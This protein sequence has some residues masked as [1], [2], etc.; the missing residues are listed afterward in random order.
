[1]DNTWV[2]FQKKYEFNPLHHHSGVFSWVI[3]VKIPYNLSDEED[4]FITGD[5]EKGRKPASK[6]H[7]VYP[8]NP[9]YENGGITTALLDVDKSYEGKILL[10]PSFLNHGVYP[11]Y[12]SDDERI[13][14]SGNMKFNNI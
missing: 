2:N 14:I 1:M 10:F 3:F 7:F 6:F 12:T 4:Y 5:H 9:I 8:V 13:T 11:F